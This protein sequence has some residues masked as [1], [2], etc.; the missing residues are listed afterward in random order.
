MRAGYV[1]IHTDK[2]IAH[3]IESFEKLGSEY[4]L[5]E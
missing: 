3:V 4:G 1:A 5:I 2:N